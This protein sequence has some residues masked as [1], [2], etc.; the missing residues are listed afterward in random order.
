M[1][2]IVASSEKEKQQLTLAFIKSTKATGFVMITIGILGILLPSLLGVALNTF[3]GI[4]FLLAAIALIFNAWQYK[5][6]DLWLWFKPFLLIAL[7]LIIFIHPAIVLSVLGLLIAIYFLI[8]GFASM[9]VSFELSSSAKILS[10]LSGIISFILGVV[11]LTNWPFDSAWIVGLTIGV[12]FL[13]DGIALLSIS[14]HL[15]KKYADM[16]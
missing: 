4:I 16:V 9:V 1:T 14:D 11:V 7:A 3:V 15:K 6:K 13:F 10:L 8:S 12:T 2:D 5:T